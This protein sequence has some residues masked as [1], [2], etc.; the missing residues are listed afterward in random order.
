MDRREKIKNIFSWISVGSGL[1]VFLLLLFTIKPTIFYFANIRKYISVL[2]ILFF[3]FPISIIVISSGIYGMY[4]EVNKYIRL[5]S[6]MGFM[7]G[8]LCC[9]LFWY[10][11]IFYLE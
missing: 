11:L 4:G 6:F 3:S 1:L 2:G 9:G 8:H 5:R 10:L 7:L